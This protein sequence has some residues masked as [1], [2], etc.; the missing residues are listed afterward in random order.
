MSLCRALRLWR[1]FLAGHEFKGFVNLTAAQFGVFLCV[2]SG[3]YACPGTCYAESCTNKAVIQPVG[4]LLLAV[5]LADALAVV[6]GAESRVNRAGNKLL[7]ELATAAVDN[8]A[9]HSAPDIGLCKLADELLNGSVRKAFAIGKV[10]PAEHFLGEIFFSSAC[11]AVSTGL[12]KVSAACFSLLNAAAERSPH[13]HCHTGAGE[14]CVGSHVCRESRNLRH[15]IESKAS[16]VRSTPFRAFNV[17][18]A[19][20]GKLCG[21]VGYCLL[22]LHCFLIFP[23]ST[24]MV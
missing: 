1:G 14:K 12:S 19:G 16:H 6:D 4:N 8:G 21:L 3:R 10:K 22:H 15:C 20:F 17:S 24:D 18:A 11:C 7:Y 23:F 2:G 5:V 9:Q 13:H